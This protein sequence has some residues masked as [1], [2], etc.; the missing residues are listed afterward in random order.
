MS[1]RQVKWRV[2]KQQRALMKELTKK[3][4]RIVEFLKSYVKKH[5]YP[6]TMREIGAY[7]GFTWPAAKGHLVALKKKG[8]IRINP[9]KSRGIE[10]LGSKYREAFELP[11]AG[12]IRAGKP[13]LALEEI[14]DHIV[15]DRN[16]FKDSDAFALRITGDS[17]VEA[18]IFD[19]DY[20]I[21]KPQRTIENGEVAVV[22]LEDEATVK[23]VY[24]E[25]RKVVLKPENKNMQPT[26]HSP[27]E[28][29]IIGRV[30]GVIR[31]L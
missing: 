4:K 12:R 2:Y 27:D 5:G 11:V 29:T 13:I 25:K 10:I 15:I 31:K 1:R 24:K 9:F 26:K 28:V 14:E 18:G 23:K 8:L 22:F 7:F 30:V 6:P 3:Q 20:V 17:M 16:L 21:V 19:G